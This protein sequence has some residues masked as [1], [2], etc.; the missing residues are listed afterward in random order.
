MRNINRAI[1]GLTTVGILASGCATPRAALGTAQNACFS[2]LPVAADAVARQGH[3]AGFHRLVLAPG[4]TLPLPGAGR[5]PIT[6]TTSTSTTTPGVKPT[7]PRGACLVAFKGTFDP[8]RITLLRGT[9]RT[10][11]F[12]IVA[13]GLRTHKV[14]AVYLTD[15]LPKY[16]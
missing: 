4:E 12:A 13:V 11:H 10:G 3:F 6:T 5:R 15:A 1:A 8:T 16:F 14:V 9:N 2:S 7:K